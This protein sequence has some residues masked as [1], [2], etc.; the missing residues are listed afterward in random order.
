MESFGSNQYKLGCD[1][2]STFLKNW[3]SFCNTAGGIF[4]SGEYP[5]EAAQEVSSN[6]MHTW[7]SQVFEPLIRLLIFESVPSLCSDRM[8]VSSLRKNVNTFFCPGNVPDDADLFTYQDFFII[9]LR[10]C[11]QQFIIFTTT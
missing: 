6:A 10:D 11:E 4:E 9:R 2:S 8:F 5:F 7:S 1:S 3:K